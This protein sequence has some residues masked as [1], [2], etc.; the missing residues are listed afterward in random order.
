MYQSFT[1]QKIM[2]SIHGALQAAIKDL[3]LRLLKKLYLDIE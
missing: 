3:I 1:T 2:L